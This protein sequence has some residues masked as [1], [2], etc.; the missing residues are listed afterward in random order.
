MRITKIYTGVG[1]RGTTRTASG[2]EVS[3]D[4]EMIALAGDL[5]ELNCWIGTIRA[6]RGPVAD[7]PSDDLY[8]VQNDL[9]N[10]GALVSSCSVYTGLLPKNRELYIPSSKDVARIEHLI[11]K[12]NADL[13]PLEEFIMPG[14]SE[15]GSFIHIT[16]AVCRRVERSYVTFYNKLGPEEAKPFAQS[17]IYLNR[18]SDLLFVL[19]RWYNKNLHRREYQWNNPNKKK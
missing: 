18:L 1:D 8:N 6:F 5:D 17:L 14:G 16:R 7:F 15:I 13:P 9:F 10:I 2:Q 19:A 3:K 12:F 11:D 4:R